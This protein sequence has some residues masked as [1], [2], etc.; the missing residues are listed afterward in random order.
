MIFIIVLIV[1]AFL[2][3]VFKLAEFFNRFNHES[4]YIQT[5]M[6]RA[7]DDKEYRYWRRELRCHYLCLIP[8]VTER[9]VSRLYHLCFYRAKHSINKKRI[10]GIFHIL[11]PSAIGA[12]ICAVCL[13]GVSWAWF[14]ASTSAGTSKIQ[15][16]TYT[17]SV[18]AMQGTT[19][20]PTTTAANS[21]TE[22]T[23]E[24]GK[25]YI[26]TI[27]PTGTSSSGYCKV[28]FEGQNYYTGQLVNGCISF[29][30]Y[31]SSDGTMTVT[32]QWGTCTAKVE[33]NMIK[34]CTQIGTKST[35]SSQ[36]DNNAASSESKK[37]TVPSKSTRSTSSNN[38][39]VSNATPKQSPSSITPSSS[40]NQT[41]EI[42]PSH[43]STTSSDATVSK[44][45]TS[46]LEDS[47]DHEL[48]KTEASDDN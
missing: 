35:D 6:H 23:I 3:L 16:A 45:T 36:S 33:N 17:V 38:S 12:C 2:I 47:T 24:S 25:K 46:S 15:T 27:K 5:Q 41:K 34:D 1:S 8:F 28:S 13:C 14:T 26:I 18:T 43:S 20:I 10:D 11:A 19:E 48:T 37:Y 9:N 39:V 22:F 4:K 40:P 32:P 42:T 30:A 21:I 31:A 7:D 29:T 44:E